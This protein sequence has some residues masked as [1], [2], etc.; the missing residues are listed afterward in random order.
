MMLGGSLYEV[1]AS[2]HTSRVPVWKRLVNSLNQQV[3]ARPGSVLRDRH[4]DMEERT[5]GE[6]G[7]TKVKWSNKSTSLC[8]FLPS[9]SKNT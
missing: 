7:S 2:S 9:R 8:A 4:F 3:R 6:D 5:N 1:C